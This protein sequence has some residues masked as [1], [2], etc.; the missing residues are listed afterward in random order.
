MSATERQRG[1]LLAQLGP[2][3]AE[4]GFEIEDINVSRVGRRHLVRVVVDGEH[5]IDLDGI[6]RVSRA[7]DHA[8]DADDPFG[9]PFVLEVSSP[10]V[11]RPLTEP[12]H[13][14]RSV[15]RLIQVDVDGRRRTG[16]LRAV[17]EDGVRLAEETEPTTGRPTDAGGEPITVGWDRLGPGQVQVEFT[18]PGGASVAAEPELSTDGTGD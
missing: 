9:S 1:Q 4:L 8:L 16:R 17:A 15:G 7:A 6:A 12:R 3:V 11:D 10:G 2:I 18:R 5:G 13:W 14:R